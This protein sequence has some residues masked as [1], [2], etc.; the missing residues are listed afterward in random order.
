MKR[1]QAPKPNR[2]GVYEIHD[3][4]HRKA[5]A[6]KAKGWKEV[7][8]ETKEEESIAETEDTGEETVQL[9]SEDGKTVDLSQGPWP[10]KAKYVK[11][12]LDLEKKPGTKDE[13]V[14]LLQDAGYEVKQ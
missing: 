13:A 8:G 6:L 1:L 11:D 12:L 9:L 2:R 4:P 5:E 14:E 7:I 10:T 3:V